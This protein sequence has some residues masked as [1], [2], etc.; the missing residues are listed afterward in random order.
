M[1]RNQFEDLSPGQLR[2]LRVLVEQ[3]LAFALA[4]AA[5]GVVFLLVRAIW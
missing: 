5:F 4:N 3:T 2:F 1:D